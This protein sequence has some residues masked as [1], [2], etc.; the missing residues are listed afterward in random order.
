MVTDAIVISSDE[1]KLGFQN[2]NKG[3][4]GFQNYNKR[5]STVSKNVEVIEINSDCE[6]DS[7]FD[8]SFGGF[9]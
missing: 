8:D 6:D 2:Y 5:L 1:E 9:R 7:D 3:L 4:S